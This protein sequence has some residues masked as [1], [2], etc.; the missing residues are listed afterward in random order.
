MPLLCPKKTAAIQVEAIT[1]GRID[2]PRHQ[3]P[4]DYMKRID[5]YRAMVDNNGSVL[6]RLKP[7]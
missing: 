4:S 3:P 7:Q 6:Q 5:T 2:I 1:I